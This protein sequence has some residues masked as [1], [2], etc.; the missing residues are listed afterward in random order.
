LHIAGVAAAAGCAP[1]STCHIADIAW[2]FLGTEPASIT[3][4][5]QL[6]NGAEAVQVLPIPGSVQ[7]P[8]STAA[9]N[10]P[11]PEVPAL[12]GHPSGDGLG[13]GVPGVTT[14]LALALVLA[15][16]AFLAVRISRQR[17]ARQARPDM[18]LLDVDDIAPVFSRYL[19]D[20][21]RRGSTWSFPNRERTDDDRPARRK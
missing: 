16:G 8:G 4:E 10:N 3:I 12:Q 15:G 1:A 21:E 11:A 20:A 9:T 5:A 19:S 13:F 6:A 2:Q 7:P 18:S 14:I 17:V